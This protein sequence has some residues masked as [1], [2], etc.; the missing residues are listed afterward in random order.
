MSFSFT[1]EYNRDLQKLK[2]RPSEKHE[3]LLE[4]IE[5]QTLFFLKLLAKSF[6]RP[7]KSMKLP[8]DSTP[9]KALARLAGGEIP[10]K[11]D[12]FNFF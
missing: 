4:E 6:E 10:G 1:L 11:H 3:H 9:T 8:S 5:F 12:F 7:K 2:V